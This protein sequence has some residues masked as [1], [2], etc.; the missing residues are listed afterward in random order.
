MPLVIP[1][2]KI[3]FMSVLYI[4][5]SLQMLACNFSYKL[6][7]FCLPEKHVIFEQKPDQFIKDNFYS[8]LVLE[9]LGFCD[10]LIFPHDSLRMFEC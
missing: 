6:N 9:G 10:F 4:N 5:I 7:V 1:L 2:Q 8:D 3:C